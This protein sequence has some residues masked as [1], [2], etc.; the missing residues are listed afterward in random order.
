MNEPAAPPRAAITA[1]AATLAAVLLGT[2]YFVHNTLAFRNAIL[3]NTT[4]VAGPYPNTAVIFVI[5]PALCGAF[6]FLL[7]YIGI[8]TGV[9]PFK[10]AEGIAG[11]VIL[12]IA[13]LALSLVP[14][15]ML[16]HQDNAFALEHG[17]VRC[18]SLFDPARQRVYAMRSYVDAYGCP[19]A[20]PP[21]E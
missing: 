15:A 4:S 6:Y 5:I 13:L 7:D 19:T 3:T 10:T 14:A 2:L 1:L 17:Y 8:K 12:G 20:A 9:S 18:S 21:Q 16:R 11:S